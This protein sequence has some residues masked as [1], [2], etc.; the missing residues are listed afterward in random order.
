MKLL[1]GWVLVLMGLVIAAPVALAESRIALVI[2]GL[3]LV[4][5]LLAL[6][7]IARP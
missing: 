1:A 2:G 7:G 3:G 4:W 5:L 6:A